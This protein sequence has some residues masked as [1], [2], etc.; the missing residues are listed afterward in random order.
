MIHWSI[1]GPWSEHQIRGHLSQVEP[2][3]YSVE[4]IHSRE[5]Q[6]QNIFNG[7]ESYILNFLI[8]K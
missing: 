3:I 6:F 1:K 7:H 5:T 4:F 2:E 8:T